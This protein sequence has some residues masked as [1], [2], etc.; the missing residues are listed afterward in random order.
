MG[1]TVGKVGKKVENQHHPK[2]KGVV[3]RVFR[4]VFR[5][6]LGNPAKDFGGS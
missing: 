4:W 3:W 5:M 1:K 2:C 6:F